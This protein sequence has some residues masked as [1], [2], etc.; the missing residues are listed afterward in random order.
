MKQRDG[1]ERFS[2]PLE[3]PVT[4]SNPTKNQ[5]RKCMLEA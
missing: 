2:K 5:I 3:D 4:N 1:S